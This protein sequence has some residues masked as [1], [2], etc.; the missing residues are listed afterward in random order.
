MSSRWLRTITASKRYPPFIDCTESM[1]SQLILPKFHQIRSLSKDN[2]ARISSSV[3]IDA[4]VLVKTFGVHHSTRCIVGGVSLNT[5]IP[6]NGLNTDEVKSILKDC[7]D[8]KYGPLASEI[9]VVVI[10]IQNT[11]LGMSPYFLLCGNP[12]SINDCNDFSSRIM[13]I[14]QQVV[15]DDGNAVV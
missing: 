2:H 15:T 11:P 5:S 10:S 8:G 13:R 6:I 9:K 12:Q 14:C 1:L 7:I 3:G 4:T